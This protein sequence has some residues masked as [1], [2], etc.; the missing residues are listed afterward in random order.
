MGAASGCTQ[1]IFINA[2]Y[3]QKQHSINQI[4]ENMNNAINTLDNGTIKSYI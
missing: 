3:L 4:K 1:P 2:I